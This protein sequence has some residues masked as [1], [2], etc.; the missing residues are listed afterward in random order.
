MEPHIWYGLPPFFF[1]SFKHEL[2]EKPD[3]ALLYTFLER[4]SVFRELVKLSQ[5]DEIVTLQQPALNIIQRFYVKIPD[6]IIEVKKSDRY[7]NIVFELD[8]GKELVIASPDLYKIKWFFVPKLNDGKLLL[9]WG[10]N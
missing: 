9:Q 10:G 8:H 1:C 5:F 4:E 6:N 2:S 7:S 3:P